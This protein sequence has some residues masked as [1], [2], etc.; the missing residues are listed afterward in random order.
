M[1]LID[2]FRATTSD[3][4]KDQIAKDRL[5]VD[6]AKLEFEKKRFTIS[7]IG[8]F[9]TVCVLL[10]GLLQF[11]S[12]AKAALENRENQEIQALES[13]RA[14]RESQFAL[15][16]FELDSD[17]RGAFIE[18]LKAFGDFEEDFISKLQAALTPE[19][20]IARS[21][22][23]AEAGDSSQ[24]L[25]S[26]RNSLRGVTSGKTRT[27]RDAR[28]QLALALSNC[29]KTICLDVVNEVFEVN[30]LTTSERYRLALGITVA[31]TKINGNINDPS[32]E[33]FSLFGDYSGKGDYVAKLRS[34]S[35]FNE[36]A[37]S[38][39]AIVALQ[40]FET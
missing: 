5:A 30:N 31:L 9:L 38:Q 1:K 6:F 24:E 21:D 15:K 39:N 20:E 4:N 2:K 36:P 23:T 17:E 26:I 37:I 10:F 8:T 33:F 35:E 34:L 19:V 13:R 11:N 32:S 22:L 18:N 3:L 28:E 14:A 25:E 29:G 16:F 12:N 27:R 7:V 40:K